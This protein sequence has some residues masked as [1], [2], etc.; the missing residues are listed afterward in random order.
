MTLFP[1]LFFWGSWHSRATELFI[2]ITYPYKMFTF[3]GFY[4]KILIFVF[5]SVPENSLLIEIVMIH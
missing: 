4:R 5:I 2:L 3:P 1:T